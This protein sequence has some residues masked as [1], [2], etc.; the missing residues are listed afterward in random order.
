MMR[1]WFLIALSCCGCDCRPPV[2]GIPEKPAI[3]AAVESPSLQAA[4]LA[5]ADAQ[6]ALAA[7][8]ARVAGLEVAQSRERTEGQRRLLAWASGLAILGA[9]IC[10][11]LAV[12]LP[13]LRLRLAMAGIACV[14]VLVLAQ[15]LAV[16][17][18]WLPLVGVCLA[19]LALGT[20]LVLAVRGLRH[21][22][23]L[24]DRL[25]AAAMGGDPAVGTI[26]DQAREVQL[27]GKTRQMINRLR[28]Q[29]PQQRKGANHG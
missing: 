18:P 16:A 24:A 20:G 10:G 17:L 12:F 19:L 3:V 29:S 13:V 5:L 26:L 7:A 6:A 11:A 25:K 23:S 2:Q 15:T 21:A 4:R 22:V 1:I 9:L 27:A 28:K 14:T 8:K